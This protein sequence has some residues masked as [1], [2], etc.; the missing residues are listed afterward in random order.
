MDNDILILCTHNRT[1]FRTLPIHFNVRIGTP[2]PFPSRSGHHSQLQIREILPLPPRNC[3]S[4]NCRSPLLPFL[5]DSHHSNSQL[6]R[7]G[8]LRKVEGGGG[9]GS[10]REKGCLSFLPPP[11]FQPSP[12]GACSCDDD[13]RRPPSPLPLPARPSSPLPSLSPV[14]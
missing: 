4:T 14:D 3:T 2:A 11:R 10:I 8:F 12:Q 5:G 1:Q 13:E 7:C 9:E 6:G